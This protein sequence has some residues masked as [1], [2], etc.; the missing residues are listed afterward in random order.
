MTDLKRI[1]EGSISEVQFLTEDSVY[2]KICKGNSIFTYL[3]T[4]SG[5]FLIQ[6]SDLMITYKLIDPVKYSNVFL[7]EFPE[8]GV[9]G[10]K[11]KVPKA[12]KKYLEYI[13]E[14]FKYVQNKTREEFFILLYWNKSEREFEIVIPRRQIL[15]GANAKYS[16]PDEEYDNNY[17]RYLEIHSHHSMPAKFSGGNGDDYD[18][19]N[20]MSSF[21]GVIGNLNQNTTINDVSISLRVWNGYSFT[22]VNKEDVFNIPKP[23]KKDLPNW[24]VDGI[25]EILEY[26]RQNK[27]KNY[28]TKNINHNMTRATS[29]TIYDNYLLNRGR[30][31]DEPPL[32]YNNVPESMLLDEDDINYGLEEFDWIDEEDLTF[33]EEDKGFVS[34]YRG[35]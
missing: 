29:T 18:E 24:I 35:K 3:F 33:H 25:E 14:A 10:V 13:I 2:N 26:S 1:N 11:T 6:N 20:K 22:Y 19:S 12:P 15:S 9:E 21:F 23:K 28:T 34:K 17:V 7:Q 32:T 31:S 27:K 16:Y 8:P 5:L 4:K 30:N